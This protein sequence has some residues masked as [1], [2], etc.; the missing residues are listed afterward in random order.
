MK[1]AARSCLPATMRR[2]PAAAVRIK[3]SA[4]VMR[5]SLQSC[6]P[7]LKILYAVL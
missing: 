3:V 4:S 2:K 6:A 7:L 1:R 5:E